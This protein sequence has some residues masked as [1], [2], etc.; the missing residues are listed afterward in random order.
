MQQGLVQIHLLSDNVGLLIHDKLPKDTG[1]LRV[2]DEKDRNVLSSTG[3]SRCEEND[4]GL[5]TKVI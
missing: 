3:R 4:S 5:L 2:V 1:D